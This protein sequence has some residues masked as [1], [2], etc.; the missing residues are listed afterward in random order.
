MKKY[1]LMI[2]MLPGASFSH[3]S[4][5]TSVYS[6]A[7]AHTPINITSAFFLSLGLALFVR[8]GAVYWRRR[9]S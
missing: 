2:S 6:H 9:T 5:V 7:V 8:L 3:E 1:I 4:S